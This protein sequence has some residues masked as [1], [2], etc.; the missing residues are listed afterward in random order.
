MRAPV[1]RLY[2]R[3]GD[4]VRDRGTCFCQVIQLRQLE[5]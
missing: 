1:F 3:V 2:L 5:I 4:V